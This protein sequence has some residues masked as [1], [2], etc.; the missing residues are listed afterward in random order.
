MGV[1][2]A[3]RKH[4][5]FMRGSATIGA[6]LVT[7][8]VGVVGS[9]LSIAIL[10]VAAALL[11]IIVAYGSLTWP[12]PALVIVALTPI[13]DRY[14]APG[15]IDPRAE[16]LAHFLSEWLLLVVGAVL[17]TQAV[18]RGTLVR[19]LWDPTTALL[20]VFGLVSV[21]SALVNAVSPTQ[22]LAGI[23]FTIDA[24]A[25][26]VLARI[27]GFTDG[28]AGRA[29]GAFVILMLIAAIVAVAQALLS[30]N[31]FGLFAL[32][33]KFGEVYRL[34]SFF[35]DPNVFATL[36][37]AAV[38]FL[39]FGLHEQP[40]R[41]RTVLVLIASC[42][43]LMALL[44]SFSRGGWFG[45]I[46][47]FGVAGAL[48]DRRALLI[49]AGLT[50]AMFLVVTVMP[51]DL[52]GGSGARPDL[53][54]STFGRIGAVGEGRDLRTLFIGNAVPLIRDH[55]LLGVGP[56]RYGGAV[57]DL[58]G[59]EVYAQYGTDKLFVDPAQHTIDNFWLHLLGE[60]GFL[61]LLA[62]VGMIGVPL[63][64]I[65]RAVRAAAW[66]RRVLLSGIAAAVIALVVNSTTTM[67][68]EANS[69]AFLF[70]LLLGMG[71]VLVSAEES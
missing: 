55:P 32:Q 34:A 61:G 57:A 68:L 49:G 39:L 59:T 65:M 1:G 10:V 67:L 38:P 8:V 58:Y 64:A 26:F 7:V 37:S 36:L 50:A 6:A 69:V 35:G 52:L 2:V 23:I 44:L 17:V 21:A 40:T 46:V 29:I 30:P 51:R 4:G 18:Q 31:L 48:L 62:F 41:Q 60:T 70:W 43:M 25:F 14:L 11:S 56:G 22:A 42:V 66:R 54:D 45:G 27:V 9:H 28:Q 71:T 24:V 33:G 16:T 20:A 63:V 5:E 47:G 15:V 53:L 12:R 13:L 3:V 19:A